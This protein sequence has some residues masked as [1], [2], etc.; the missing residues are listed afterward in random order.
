MFVKFNI[1]DKEKIL[2]S[3]PNNKKGLLQNKKYCIFIY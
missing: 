2:E 3:S 1:K